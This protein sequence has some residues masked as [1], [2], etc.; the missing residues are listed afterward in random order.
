MLSAV[1]FDLGGTL[2]GD[3]LH[4]L[5]RFDRLYAECGRAVPRDRLREA[6][7]AAG[8]RAKEDDAIQSMALPAMVGRLLE[9]QFTHLGLDDAA[10]KARIVAAFD[11]QVRPAA[12]VNRAVLKALHDRGLTLGVVSNAC[13]NVPVLCEDFGFA[14]FLSVTIDSRRVGVEKPDPAIFRLALEQ[15]RLP[16]AQV[17]MVGDSYDRDILPAAS[18]GMPTAWLRTASAAADQ[19]Y[20]PDIAIERLAD[21]VA[22]IDVRE[23]ALA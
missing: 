4:W 7:D 11:A 17:L 5:D 1:L 6:Y 23:R 8:R 12:T 10:L 16:A 15:L 21:L 18:L 22:A 13:G 20:Q 19:P 3:A 14:P 2:D 9:W